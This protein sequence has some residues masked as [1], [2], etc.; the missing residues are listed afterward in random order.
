[1]AE[2]TA[3]AS[4]LGTNLEKIL[5]SDDIK[6]GDQPGYELCKALYL[7]HAL[8][9]KIAEAPIAMAQSQQR[10]VTVQSAPDEVVRVF[11]EE[12]GRLDADGAVFNTYT[13]ARVYGA[14]TLALMVD[15]LEPDKPVDYENLWKKD[16]AFNVLDPLNT[17]GSLMLDQNPN[18]INF[19]K[20]TGDVVIGGKS[21]H[22]SRTVVKFNEKPIY[23]GYT[24]SAYGFVGRSVYQRALFPMKT[25][26][27]S[28]RTDDMVTHKAGL[29]IE[30]IDQP[31]SIGDRLSMGWLGF[32]RD[33]LKHAKT[34]QVI[35]IG[36]EDAIET[37]DMNNVD[38]AIQTTRSNVIKNIATAA[39][40]PARWLDN[41]TMVEGFSEG[42]EDSKKEASYVERCREDARKLY[43]FTDKVAMY[44]AWTPEFYETIQAA[45]P[46]QYEG[47]DFKTAFTDWRNNFS[48]PWPS[49]LI[50]P[51]SEK[52]KGEDVKLKAIIA[53]LEVLLPVLDPENTAVLMA[54]AADNFNEYEL[55]F[56][57]R[58]E[59]DFEALTNH[60]ED[61]AERA[62]QQ[63][64]APQEPGAA[65]PFSERDARRAQGQRLIASL[66]RVAA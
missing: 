12:R 65:P 44:R 53:L 3:D 49:L 17:G 61:Q 64:Q 54:W 45:Y 20:S 16:V 10:A 13:L 36:R 66:K 35:S 50:E 59:L 18:S 11:L 29:L 2:L 15:G 25:F 52:A 60:L 31:G 4:T 38:T 63:A 26:I 48:A 39:D 46:E 42:S 19:L 40:M 22:P 27:Q 33:I 37:L 32:K 14:A 41:E 5:S 28:M 58:L 43:E 62:A 30:K 51:D 23:L 24:S 6:P 57:H 47:V 34:G 8:G 55:L 21:Y 56:A 1:M 9:A 7:F